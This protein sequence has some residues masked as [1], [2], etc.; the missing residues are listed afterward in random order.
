MKRV[1]FLTLLLA[2][3]SEVA[4]ARKPNGRKSIAK[5]S[6]KKCK[7]AP[8]PNEL[9]TKAFHEAMQRAFTS[10][11]QHA[12]TEKGLLFKMI[13]PRKILESE[14]PKPW[15]D[16][17]EE[18]ETKLV[19]LKTDMDHV[20]K[21]FEA[22]QNARDYAITTRAS[23]IP[24]CGAYLSP[25]AHPPGSPGKKFLDARGHGFLGGNGVPNQG[26][27]QNL[28]L[29]I[30]VRALWFKDHG[31]TTQQGRVNLCCNL[32]EYR[33]TIVACEL[34]QSMATAY[35][36]NPGAGIHYKEDGARINM[37]CHAKFI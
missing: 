7:K 1:L 32:V 8:T 31:L 12:K 20:K 9:A 26:V 28:G 6:T 10:K 11:L 16:K 35:G 15:L 27:Q 22:Y 25:Q 30:E 3:S 36:E 18:L 34:S 14:D 24:S 2:L 29:P 5:S 17:I 21:T 13:F 33:T 4:A 37:I 23:Y 19:E